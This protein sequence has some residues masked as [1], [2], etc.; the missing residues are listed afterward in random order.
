MTGCMPEL[1]K[2]MQAKQHKLHLTKRGKLQ[3]VNEVDETGS[4][5]SVKQWASI[6]VLELARSCVFYNFG[7]LG[8]GCRQIEQS[9]T[10]HCMDNV[11]R[12]LLNLCWSCETWAC[13]RR[14]RSGN[15][16]LEQYRW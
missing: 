16:Q 13:S 9:R 14:C 10:W 15:Y 1:R 3:I 2:Q 5:H 6:K 7:H 12:P 8:F 4:D 11:R